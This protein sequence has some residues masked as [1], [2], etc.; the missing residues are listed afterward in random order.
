MIRVG[1][2]LTINPEIIR[3]LGSGQNS[4]W[5]AA[6]GDGSENRINGEA[7]AET[8]EYSF[9]LAFLTAGLMW[10]R[11]KF[12]NRDKTKEDLAAEKEAARINKTA[13]AL[14]AQLKDCLQAAQEGMISQEA[15]DDLIDTLEEMD[16]YDQA[17]KLTVTNVREA[18]EIRGRI[19]DFTAAIEGKTAGPTHPEGEKPEKGEFAL[20]RKQLIRQ[21]EL[22][23][24][25]RSA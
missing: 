2:Q 24:G 9:S 5:S 3:E 17:G 8:A 11:K 23:A 13:S 15:L 19:T 18:A 4:L 1:V 10:A 7:V 14:E 21:K 6:H 22:I 25:K 20:I 16:G 12:R